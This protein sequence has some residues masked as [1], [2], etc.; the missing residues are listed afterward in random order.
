MAVNLRKG[1]SINLR[2]TAPGLTKI[3]MGLGWDARKSSGADFDLDACVF[4]LGANGKVRSDADFIFF[5]QPASSCGSVRHGGDN[6]TGAGEGDDE[7]VHVDLSGIPTSVERVI[8]CVTIY[9]GADRRQ[10]FGM[11][12]NAFIRVVDQ[13]NGNEIARYD[14]S[15]DY[16]META[17][18]F[19]E[20]ARDG[21]AFRFKAM[22]DGYTDELGELAAR[23]G[24]DA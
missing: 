16:S 20:L 18:V 23:F 14:L 6:R 7:S 15:E 9:D 4:M 2:K 19:G 22:G 1:G 10:S 11:V 8:F 3:T 21:S 17:V 5:N 12:R 24:V 13:G